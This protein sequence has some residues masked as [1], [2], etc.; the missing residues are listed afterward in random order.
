MRIL[1]MHSRYQQQGGED[2]SFRTEVE[3][4]RRGGHEVDLA[5]YDNHDVEKLGRARTAIRT[6]WSHP[7]VADVRRRLGA[8]PYDILHVQNYFPMI[9]PAVLLTGGQM[10]VAT[11][12]ALRNYRLMCAAGQLFRDG[13]DCDICVGRFVPWAGVRLGCFRG[14]VAGSAALAGMIA[15]HKLLGT[16][17]QHTDALVPVSDYVRAMYVRGGFPTERLHSKPNISLAE[18]RPG[19]KERQAIFAG[20][21]TVE[22]GVDGLIAAWRLAAPF[23]A[24][25]LI[26]GTGPQ[27]DHLKRLADGDPTIHF[28]GHRDHGELIV[29]LATSRISVIP[30]IWNEPFGR[31]AV[32]AFSVGTPV[33]A[34]DKGGLIEIIEGTGG[35]ATYPAGDIHALSQ[36]LLQAMND[37]EWWQNVAAAARI[38]F[39]EKYSE[40]AILKRTEDI[41]SIAI[42]RRA[43][44]NQQADTISRVQSKN[45]ID[46]GDAP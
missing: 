13:H 24:R 43:G 41:Y 39:V 11:V 1:M 37:N 10:G 32:E 35:G 22:K 17:H 36:L 21:L 16:W 19:E 20:R 30:S 45:C 38:G 25:L 14:S 29:M 15:T 18:A 46:V 7:A 33:I 26:V 3:L 44:L 2:I 42:A 8:Q 12:Q 31:T 40:A 6:I 34:A 9:S 27:E 4:L 23:N 5:V 28:M